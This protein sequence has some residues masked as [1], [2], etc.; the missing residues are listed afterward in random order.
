MTSVAVIS[1]THSTTFAAA[2]GRFGRN[3]R[4]RGNA[5]DLRIM[6]LSPSFVGCAPTSCLSVEPTSRRVQRSAD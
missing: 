1:A 3:E 4:G 2:G 5:G 6:G